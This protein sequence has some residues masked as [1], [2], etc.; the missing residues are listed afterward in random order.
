MPWLTPNWN[1]GAG[2]ICRK[3]VVPAFF[4]EEVSGALYDMTLADNWES[5]GDMTPQ[6]C[7]DAM[8]TMLDAWYEGG[9]CD[10]IGSVVAMVCDISNMPSNVIPC[11]GRTVNAGTREGQILTIDNYMSL[12]D[13]MPQS[14]KTEVFSP[15]STTS[16]FLTVPDMRDRFLIGA[17]SDA[18]QLGGDYPAH[19]TGGEKEHTLTLGEI[20]SHAHTLAAPAGVPVVSPGPVYAFGLP[21]VQGGGTTDSAGG[22]AAHNNTPRYYSLWYAV[23]AK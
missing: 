3:V 16:Y 18:Q 8:S 1:E 13:I 6:E 22:G 15:P 20:P 5:H 19:A 23:V 10:M 14:K 12:W 11:D 7:A 4:I 2:T 21:V 9:G 17:D